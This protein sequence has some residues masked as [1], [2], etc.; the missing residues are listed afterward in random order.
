MSVG[1]VD[2]RFP[3]RVSN[4]LAY[5]GPGTASEAA[6]QPDRYEPAGPGA[7]QLRAVLVAIRGGG[8]T[9]GDLTAA[10]IVELC[11]EYQHLAVFLVKSIDLTRRGAAGI[12]TGA[13]DFRGHRDGDGPPGR[14]GPDAGLP[15]DHRAGAAAARPPDRAC[16]RRRL[17]RDGARRAAV[18]G[19]APRR[20]G[21]VVGVAIG[22]LG[23]W[24]LAG[25]T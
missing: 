7:P 5:P 20:F 2:P 6:A 25:A 23:I 4:N 21:Q 9:R 18:A 8:L 12:R 14:P 24:L 11:C 22:A 16:D 1:F 19:A 13:G 15:L 10:S 17:D 3:V